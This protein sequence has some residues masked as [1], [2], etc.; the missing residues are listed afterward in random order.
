MNRTGEPIR[1]SAWQDAKNET[2]E[3]ICH[4]ASRTP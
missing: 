1:H 4:A 2:G 3:R